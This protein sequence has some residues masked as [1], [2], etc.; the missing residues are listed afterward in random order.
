MLPL[1]TSLS[2]SLPLSLY[3]SLSLPLSLSTSLSLSASLSLYLS[4]SLPSLGAAWYRAGD[5]RHTSAHDSV[6]L[7]LQVRPPSGDTTPCQV[8]PVILHGVVW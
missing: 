1:S 2:L 4:L 7:G 5:W 3:H 6:G 8:T